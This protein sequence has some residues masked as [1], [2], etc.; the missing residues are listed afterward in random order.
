MKEYL[1]KL[2]A[3][4]C[5]F[6]ALPAKL[7]S[8]DIKEIPNLKKI[9]YSVKNYDDKTHVILSHSFTIKEYDKNAKLIYHLEL[10]NNDT[11][12]IEKNIYNEK[13]KIVS[14]FRKT[15]YIDFFYGFGTGSIPKYS[16]CFIITY[17]YDAK[18]NELKN[19]VERKE[20][21][22]DTLWKKNSGQNIHNSHYKYSEND[23]ILSLRIK[24]SGSKET[25]YYE[26][27]EYGTFGKIKSKISSYTGSDTLLYNWEYDKTGNKVSLNTVSF[28]DTIYERTSQKY[29]YNV[30]K[31]LIRIEKESNYY[32]GE[33]KVTY[34]SNNKI[35]STITYKDLQVINSVIEPRIVYDTL[36]PLSFFNDFRDENYYRKLTF[37]TEK[38]VIMAFIDFDGI[39]RLGYFQYKDKS[40]YPSKIERFSKHLSEI[41]KYRKYPEYVMEYQYEFY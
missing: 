1:L 41:K 19:V 18:G 6:C 3:L 21:A 8:Q 37:D 39:L 34:L 20:F 29:Y 15:N 32:P 26:V 23:S 13:G 2:F 16:R 12:Y 28:K 33:K 5:I 11:A 10:L 31:N 27:N 9:A 7:F 4:A 38:R 40:I 24:S 36:P 30:G 17:E 25:E 35:D 22:N 14:E